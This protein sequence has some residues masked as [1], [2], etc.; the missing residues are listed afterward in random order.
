MPPLAIPPRP[1]TEPASEA[2]TWRGW[3][4]WLILSVTVIAWL[5]LKLP[6]LGE[7]QVR[8]PGLHDA[9]FITT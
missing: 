1:V 3:T 2:G 6:L 9:V 7:M 8:W 4:P 5:H